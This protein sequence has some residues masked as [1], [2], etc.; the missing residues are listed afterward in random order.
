MKRPSRLASLLHRLR[1][2]SHFSRRNMSWR[3]AW[4]TAARVLD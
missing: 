2:A 3:E 4:D 1:A